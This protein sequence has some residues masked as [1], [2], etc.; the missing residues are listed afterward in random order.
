[1]GRVLDVMEL[2]G[3]EE[4]LAAVQQELFHSTDQLH[5]IQCSNYSLRY[6]R[7]QR[8]TNQYIF[9]QRTATAMFPRTLDS[10]QYLMWFIPKSKSFTQNAS[11][12]NLSTKSLDYT[13]VLVYVHNKYLVLSTFCVMYFSHMCPT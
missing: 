1:M 12:K 7:Q 8:R 11:Q 13:S 3:D 4:E 9:T 2:I 5:H 10:S 6:T